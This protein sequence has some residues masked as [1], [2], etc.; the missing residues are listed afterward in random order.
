M[1]SWHMDTIMNH[2]FT[3]FV[4]LVDIF[5]KIYMWLVKRC[6]ELVNQ[7]LLNAVKVDVLG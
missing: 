4:Y 1:D 3:N 7:I 2:N 5:K 6:S